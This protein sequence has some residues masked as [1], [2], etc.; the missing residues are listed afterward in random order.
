[1]KRSQTRTFR[2]ANPTIPPTA[3]PTIAP[4]WLLL[5]VVGVQLAE[6]EVVDDD[7]ED[8]EDVAVRELKSG[9]EQLSML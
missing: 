5:C 4:T 1:M 6:D 7:D 2:A 3:P 8:V 9:G